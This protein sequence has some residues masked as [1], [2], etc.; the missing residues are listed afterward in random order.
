[1]RRITANLHLNPEAI[2]A[3]KH[4]LDLPH[5]V[6]RAFTD[7]VE[8]LSFQ[9]LAQPFRTSIGSL[10]QSWMLSRIK[11]EDGS[12]SCEGQEGNPAFS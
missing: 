9:N 7:T 10:C 2:G 1:M 6:L 12:K 4:H 8:I 11:A 3:N 5:T